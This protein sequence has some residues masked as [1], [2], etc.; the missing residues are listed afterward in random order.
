LRRTAL[1]NV[2]SVK[3]GLTDSPVGELK[4]QTSVVN[5]KQKGCILYLYNKQKF[6][7]GLKTHF[8]VEGVHNFITPFKFGDDR[9]WNFGLAKGQCLSFSI[10]FKKRPYY[11]HTTV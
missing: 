1:F 8:L 10:D 11:T 9:F 4:N 3:I 5:F 2:S 7:C 6:F